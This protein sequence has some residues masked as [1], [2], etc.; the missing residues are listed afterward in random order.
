M[1]KRTE[2]L[3]HLRA[4]QA[5]PGMEVLWLSSLNLETAS[6]MSAAEAAIN[7]RKHQ[8]TIAMLRRDYSHAFN[9]PRAEDCD[10]NV[11]TR[12][13][14]CLEQSIRLH[15]QKLTPLARWKYAI[16]SKYQNK[17]ARKWKDFVKDCLPSTA[18]VT[19]GMNGTIDVRKS[20][21]ATRKTTL[22]AQLLVDA[23]RVHTGDGEPAGVAFH[24][25][26]VSSDEF[27]EVQRCYFLDAKT[28]LARIHN[29]STIADGLEFIRKSTHSDK[30]YLTANAKHGRLQNQQ[31][32][33]EDFAKAAGL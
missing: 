1:P 33:N 7:I 23:V 16:P 13:V 24:L 30:W 15:R 31:S 26:P 6:R 2:K 11:F 18:I 19:V 8:R 22:F 3:K 14:V 10:D 9:E 21:R 29:P 27:G 28:C 5:F 32:F 25:T 12:V 17:F 20:K 4:G